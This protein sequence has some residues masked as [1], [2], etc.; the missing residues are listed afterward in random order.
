MRGDGAGRCLISIVACGSRTEFESNSC[1]NSLLLKSNYTYQNT[2]LLE[3][4]KSPGPN[5]CASDEDE[6]EDDDDD[7]KISAR[8]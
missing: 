2:L 5:F 8:R 3:S 6:E 1:Q 4:N 7:A